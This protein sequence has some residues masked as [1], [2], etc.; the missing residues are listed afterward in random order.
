MQKRKG[1]IVCTSASACKWH[2]RNMTMKVEKMFG[3]TKSKILKS[4]KIIFFS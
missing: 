4:K 2:E 3:K 1:G